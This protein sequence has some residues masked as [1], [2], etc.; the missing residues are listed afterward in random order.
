MNFQ[1]KNV[2]ITGASSGIGYELV[3]QLAKEGCNLAISA[4]RIELLNK[5]KKEINSSVK[6]I[7]YEL[8]VTNR[9]MV[10]EVIQK[11][12]H[13]FGKID[14]AILNAG[15]SLRNEERD[16]D[17]DVGVK[18]I[19]VNFF[20]MINCIDEL[21]DDFKNNNSGMIV[22]VSS[23]ADNKGFPK[24]GFYTASKAAATVLLESLRVEFR[25]TNIKI[26]TVR[27]G[28]IRTPMTDKNE[29][30]MPFLMDADEAAS[31]IVKGIKK[32]KRIIEFPFLTVFSAKFLKCIPTR[33]FEWIAS[34]KLIPRKD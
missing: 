27:P 11:V 10:K 31:I 23:I 3:K 12:N 21:L 17:I 9:Q 4:R 8:D 20:G 18:T 34:R 5:L 14:I 28:F 30:H 32:E 13:D 22:G 16:F 19:N 1:N 29:F 26:I 15:V 25:K 6:I 24:S 33:L 2:F 7:P